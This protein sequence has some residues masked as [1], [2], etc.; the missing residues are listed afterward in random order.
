[1]NWK[2]LV[3]IIILLLSGRFALCGAQGH[4]TAERPAETVGISP[5][6]ARARTLYAEGEKAYN[7]CDFSTA[8]DKWEQVL[9][10]KPDSDR[11]K[12]MLDW[13]RKAERAQHPMKLPSS[14]KEGHTTSSPPAKGGLGGVP[15]TSLHPQLPRV[16]TVTLKDLRLGLR[17]KVKLEIENDQ[18]T[19]NDVIAKIWVVD[20][21][22]TGEARLEYCDNAGIEVFK[23]LKKG[24]WDYAGTVQIRN[25]KAVKTLNYLHSP[26][27]NAKT[28]LWYNTI[29]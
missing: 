2:S 9:K 17:T 12:M 10:L 11:T 6:L 14:V 26:G 18:N 4:G 16:T 21:N 13:A 1:M 27:D 3:L 8:I 25:G 7:R 29:K 19:Q 24:P 28:W 23:E 20:K 22:L 15:G 5:T